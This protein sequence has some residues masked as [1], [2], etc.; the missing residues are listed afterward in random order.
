MIPSVGADGE[1]I[2][3]SSGKEFGDAGFYFLLED[4]RGG[5]WSQFISS[6]RD[7]LTIRAENGHL[8]AEQ[9]LTLWKRGVVTFNY[10]IVPKKSVF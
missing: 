5:K 9:T 1:L 10:R 8:L 6:F 2:L 3:E 7:R 4:S